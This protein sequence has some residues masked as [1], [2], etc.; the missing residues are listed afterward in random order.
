MVEEWE[1][2]EGR[3][4]LN[5]FQKYF[6]SLLLCP[7]YSTHSCDPALGPIVN[8]VNGQSTSWLC[9]VCCT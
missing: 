7:A 9:T 2:R 4:V 1:G 5:L 6:S 3:A 8:L